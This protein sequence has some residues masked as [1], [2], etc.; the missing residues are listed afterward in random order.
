MAT[1]SV[2]PAR[3]GDAEGIARLHAD[4]WRRHYRGAYADSFLDGDVEADRRE[5]WTARLAEPG[6][7][8]T[9]PG[10]TLR[11][12]TLLAEDAGG[13]AGF[14]HTVF[15]E[16]PRWGSLIDN[17]HVRADLRRTGIGTRLLADAFQAIAAAASAPSIYLWVLEQNVAAQAFYR[18]RGAT[19]A[20]RCPCRPPTIPVVGDLI[21]TALSSYIVWE[22][23]RLG[24]PLASAN[25]ASPPRKTI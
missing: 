13:L 7:D 11:G 19:R 5:V 20:E 15:D 3:P 10:A 14:V 22:A 1:F 24:V 12:A 17:L 9:L 23:R 2:R 16:D 8:A 25:K 18:S 6:H 21:T 4:S